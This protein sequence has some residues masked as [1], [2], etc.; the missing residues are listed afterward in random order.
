MATIIKVNGQT[1]TIAP[2]S[3]ESI[4]IDSIFAENKS[5]ESFS[6]GINK[7]LEALNLI[8]DTKAMESFGYKSTEAVMDKVKA[9][10]QA[11]LAKLKEFWEKVK[12]FVTVTI[13]NY[14]KQLI[15]KISHYLNG[16]TCDPATFAD[17]IT[18]NPKNLPLY[19]MVICQK[20]DTID[21][22]IGIPGCIKNYDQALTDI[23]PLAEAMEKTVKFIETGK[24]SGALVKWIEESNFDGNVYRNSVV[25]AFVNMS[26]SIKSLNDGIGTVLNIGQDNP[27]F[28]NT[29]IK[30]T[31]SVIACCS[32]L[33]TMVGDLL[34]R[35][36][37]AFVTSSK[38]GAIQNAKDKISE[39]A[40]SAG[41]KI[42]KVAGDAKNKI[43]SLFA[44]KITATAVEIKDLTAK[45]ISS[46]AK[47]LLA[48]EGVAK[49]AAMY[50]DE[51]K[52]IEL[53]GTDEN[54]NPNPKAVGVIKFVNIETNIQAKFIEDDNMIVIINK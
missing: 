12:K 27:D 26:S 22:L 21:K 19:E 4:T 51:S 38:Q 41:G 31:Q 36:T 7:S 5:I 15:S 39:V 1:I 2:K 42:Q 50:K 9:A 11:V 44:K 16:Y 53:I 33:E 34:N 18:E 30:P 24:A 47:K 45:D 48:I 14:I 49:V 35:A 25:A 20:K 8:A 32:K 6:E 10:G 29:Y 3:V 54:N 28:A 40:Q 13:P 37:T 23:P 43:K 46:E 52:T 17:K